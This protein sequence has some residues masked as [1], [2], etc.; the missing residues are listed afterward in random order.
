MVAHFLGCN[1]GRFFVATVVLFDL[2]DNFEFKFEFL[3]CVHVYNKANL[4][5]SLRSQTSHAFRKKKVC[6][7][8]RFAFC[9]VDIV[10]CV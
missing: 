9:S 4:S 7:A 3:C 8:K 5:Y 2:F 6:L 10:V 1:L